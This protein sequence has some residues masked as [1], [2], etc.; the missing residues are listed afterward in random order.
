M[1]SGIADSIS[2]AALAALGL[3]A[4]AMWTEACVLVPHW[5]SLP[6]ES[7]FAWYRA[8]DRRLVRFFGALTVLVAV[9]PLAAALAAFATGASNR[10]AASAIAVASLAAVALFPAYF[11]KANARF[12]AASIPPSELPAELAR[13]SAWHWAR[14]GLAT[15]AFAGAI[16]AFA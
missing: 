1:P 15:A 16:A 12:G 10:G 6:P 8:N 2:L 7:F 9:V 13:W 4:G 14:T 5:R 11:A 3:Y